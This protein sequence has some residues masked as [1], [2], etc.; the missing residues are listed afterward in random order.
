HIKDYI[1]Y[2]ERDIEEA[3]RY[4]AKAKEKL[5]LIE[6]IEWRPVVE[7]NRY[8]SRSLNR[9]EYCVTVRYIAE[10][11]PQKSYYPTPSYSKKFSGKERK[12]AFEYA[13]KLAKELGAE[14]ERSGF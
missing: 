1:T 9:V 2:T 5:E 6:S 12:A 7:L 4:I 14:I 3:R 10:D 8:K 11:D 13:E